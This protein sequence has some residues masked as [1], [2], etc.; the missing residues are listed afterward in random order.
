[1]TVDNPYNRV[2]M[3]EGTWAVIC[4]NAPLRDEDLPV[5]FYRPEGVDREPALATR[6]G[7]TTREDAAHYAASIH[8][9][10]RPMVAKLEAP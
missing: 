4:L 3:V 8:P 2:K 6:S 7:F 5:S 1:M 10:W 9:S